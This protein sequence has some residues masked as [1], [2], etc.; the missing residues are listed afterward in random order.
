MLCLHPQER[1]KKKG[2]R[3]FSMRSGGLPEQLKELLEP[4]KGNSPE[5]VIGKLTHREER[6]SD[7]P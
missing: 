1:V 5:Q 3:Q 7:M 6:E 4:L 2:K